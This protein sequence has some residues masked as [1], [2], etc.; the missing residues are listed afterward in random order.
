MAAC[1]ASTLLD[2][3]GN[4]LCTNIDYVSR[5]MSSPAPLEDGRIGSRIE[6]YTGFWQKDMD[7]EAKVD[8]ENRVDNYTDVINGI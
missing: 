6:N 4:G 3:F 7:K 2:R 1:P 8:T 5:K